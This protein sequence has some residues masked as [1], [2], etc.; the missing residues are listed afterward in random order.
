M[1]EEQLL[2]N[3]IGSIARGAAPLMTLDDT[4]CK[5]CTNKKLHVQH[6]CQTTLLMHT[7]HSAMV[8]IYT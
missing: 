6:I 8:Y 5:I 7:Q 1:T 3:N 4:D 2:S